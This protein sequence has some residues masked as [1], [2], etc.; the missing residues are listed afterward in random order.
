M[1][2]SRHV[3]VTGG[4]RGIGRAVAAA[5]SAAGDRVTIL[6]RDAASL[7]RAAAEIG[8][9]GFEAADVTDEAALRAAFR[10]AAEARGPVEVLVANAGGAETA[11][12]ERT[13]V[14]TLTR[15]LTLNLVSVHVAAQEVLPA[16]KAAGRGR[17]LA[18]A[19]TAALKGYAYVSAYCAAKHAVLGLVRAL[20][21]ETA[22]TGV[23]VNAICPGYSDTDLVAG[24][25]DRIAEKT[26]RSREAALAEMTK[27][28]PQ[29][30]LVPPEDVAD[31]ALWL[32]GEGAASV[33]GQ[34]ISVSGGE[35]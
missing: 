23:T 6:G 28:N 25:L 2:E 9:A 13:S 10:R 5:F 24:A 14:E 34:A 19:S 20:A 31:A 16:M 22:R 7:D 32:A 3:L 4:S 30:R 18:V 26:G 17:I 33:T 21:Q 15:M 12:F 11:S 29:G 8:A 35:V 27:V 1:A